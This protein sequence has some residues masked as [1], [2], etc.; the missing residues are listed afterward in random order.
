MIKGF[1]TFLITVFTF[2]LEDK[3]TEIVVIGEIANKDS[4]EVNTS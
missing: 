2:L 1:K 4:I 3:I